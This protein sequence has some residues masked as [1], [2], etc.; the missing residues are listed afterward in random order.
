MWR[1]GR[2][3]KTAMSSDEFIL[4]LPEKEA[5]RLREAYGQSGVIL[6]YGSGGSTVLAAGMSRKLVFSVESDR[7]WTLR[8]QSFIDRRPSSSAVT[9]YHVDIGPTGEWGRPINES[10]W[11]SYHKYPT[12]IW[13]EPFF[14]HPDVILIDGRFRPACFVNACMRITRPVTVLFDDYTTRPAYSV[15]ERFSKP[16][17]LVGRM[18]EFYIEPRELSAADLSL[19]MDLAA[20]ATFADKPTN[21]SG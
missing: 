7:N 12:R 5:D 19:L 20:R 13:D 17:R 21:Y 10:G 2:R 1:D 4:S 3:S 16:R 8:L 11:R 15:V 6:E 18:A 14:R 9:V